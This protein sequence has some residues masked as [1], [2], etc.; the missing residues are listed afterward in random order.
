[1]KTSFSQVTFPNLEALDLR[2]LNGQ[3]IWDIFT[4][5]SSGTQIS[6]IMESSDMRIVSNDQLADRSF[7]NLKFLWV[8][9]CNFLLKLIP[10]HILKS[11]SNLKKLEIANCDSL[12][13][14]FDFGEVNNY[15]EIYTFHLKSLILK[16]LPKLKT[17]CRR[18]F[19]EMSN[20][21]SEVIVAK[22][23][24]SLEVDRKKLKIIQSELPDAKSSLFMG[25]KVPLSQITFQL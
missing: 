11:L 4:S 21:G 18:G 9:G 24:F 5:K 13:V 17:V 20:C 7:S 22:D 14:V 10:F 2:F 1:M 23:E 15:E 8:F 12:E 19:E 25:E 16:N 3:N 6:K